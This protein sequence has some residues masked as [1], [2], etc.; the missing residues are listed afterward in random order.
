MFYSPDDSKATRIS[1]HVIFWIGLGSMFALFVFLFSS[2]LSIPQREV[3][4]EIDI[5][6]RV[7]I[8][9]PEDEKF[10]KKSFFSF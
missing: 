6:N 10:A 3:N 2:D 1:K 8:C 5:K 7:N 9:L 4:V